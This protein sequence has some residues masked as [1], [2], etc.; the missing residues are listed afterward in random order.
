MIFKRVISNNRVAPGPAP[1]SCDPYPAFATQQH[2]ELK[3]SKKEEGRNI[4]GQNTK[5]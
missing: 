1:I 5:N 4:C 2:N 3:K